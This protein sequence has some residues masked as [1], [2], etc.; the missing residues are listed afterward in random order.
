MVD[1]A[2]TRAS[3]GRVDRA[4]MSSQYVPG[5]SGQASNSWV[6]VRPSVHPIAHWFWGQGAGWGLTGEGV[7]AWRTVFAG[8]EPLAWQRDAVGSTCENCL[9]HNN[10][11]IYISS[12]G[13]LGHVD[14]IVSYQDICPN[15][16]IV[17]LAQSGY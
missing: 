7:H 17:V 3:L 2:V 1:I 6:A 9:G 12:H 8:S 14:F 15:I 5:H 10:T 13:C 11:S 4:T 16:A